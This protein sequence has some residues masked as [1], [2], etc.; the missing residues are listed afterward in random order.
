MFLYQMLLDQHGILSLRGQN[1]TE[2]QPPGTKFTMG[3]PD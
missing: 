2:H 1:I 3:K